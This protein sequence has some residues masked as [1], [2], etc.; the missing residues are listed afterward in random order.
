MFGSRPRGLTSVPRAPASPRPK[1]RVLSWAQ[2]ATSIGFGT[3][4]AGAPNSRAGGADDQH[5]QR[6]RTYARDA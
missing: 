4:D 3:D 6:G 5:R 2:T 1:A